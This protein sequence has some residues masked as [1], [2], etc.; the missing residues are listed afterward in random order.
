MKLLTIQE[1]FEKLKSFDLVELECSIC[2][3]TFTKQKRIYL[4][5]VRGYK[6][7]SS[8][9]CSSDC[10]AKAR[11]ARINITCNQCSKQIEK[12]KSK[13]S[14]NNFCSKRCAAIWNNSHKLSGTR[15]SKL[16]TWLQARL[17]EI[18]P[19]LEFHF[20]RKDAINSELDIYIPSLKLAFELNGIFHYEPIFGAEKLAATQNNDERKFQACL[21]RGIELCIIDTNSMKKFTEEKAKKFLFIVSLVIE[22]LSQTK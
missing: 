2:L 10:A 16:E 5:A 21:E 6:G 18:F 9:F 3:S 7:Y 4:R 14:K 1:K 17:V 20:N 8:S 15:V 13:L 11:V 19:S 12:T 22:K